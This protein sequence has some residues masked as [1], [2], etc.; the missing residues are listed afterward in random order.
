MLPSSLL[1]NVKY[2]SKKMIDVITTMSSNDMLKNLLTAHS[3]EII[4]VPGTQQR[5]EI[6]D[7]PQIIWEDFKLNYIERVNDEKEDDDEEDI[8]FEDDDENMRGLDMMFGQMNQ[9]RQIHHTPWG[10]FLADNPLSPVNLYELKVAH[11]KGFKITSIPN[12]EKLMSEVDGVALFAK[13]DPYF[14]VMAPAKL[15]SV[16]EVKANIERA[17][18]KALNIEI[19]NESP[20]LESYAAQAQA[21]SHSK[22]VDDG[23]ENIVLVFPEP[24][25]EVEIMENPTEKELNE[26]DKL[27]K[28][29]KDLIVFKN[30]ELYEQE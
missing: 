23:V 10:R 30:G 9:A 18:Y 5:S 3:G 22:F 13:L 16:P 25:V 6:E 8:I 26:V 29:L 19:R 15:Y 28:Q 27:S 14:I 20:D 1:L 21:V 11:L 17:I 2:S 7:M 12:F 4:Q 24:N